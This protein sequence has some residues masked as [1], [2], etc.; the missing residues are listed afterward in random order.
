MGDLCRGWHFGDFAGDS[1]GGGALW[2]AVG[3][4]CADGVADGAWI[5]FARV[6]DASGA[7]MLAGAGVVELV[8]A[9]RDEHER[10]AGGERRERGAGAAVADNGVAPRE[11]RREWQPPLGVERTRCGWKPA[12]AQRWIVDALERELLPDTNDTNASGLSR[13]R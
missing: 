6:Q 2:R 3:Q 8:G 7:G 10:Q 13:R 11:Q 5:D 12:T 1:L 4:H 9:L